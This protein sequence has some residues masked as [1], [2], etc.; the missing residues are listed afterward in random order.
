MTYDSES[1]IIILQIWA[2]NTMA[3]RH[4]LEKPPPIEGTPEVGL[5][6][7]PPG[8]S[9]SW[10]TPLIAVVA[11]A[12]VLA[13]AAVVASLVWGRRGTEKRSGGKSQGRVA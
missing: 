9:F 5:D 7:E 11:T 2:S 8:V 1:D 10:L 6:E 12:V 3:Y 13:V 4:A